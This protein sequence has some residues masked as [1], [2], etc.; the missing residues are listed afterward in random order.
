MLLV[1]WRWKIG[2]HLDFRKCLLENFE[3]NPAYYEEKELLSKIHVLC[4]HLV[5]KR[6]WYSCIFALY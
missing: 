2:V 1:L 3:K 5:K 4:T 6:L